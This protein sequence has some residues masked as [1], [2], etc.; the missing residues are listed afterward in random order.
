[1]EGD[2][3]TRFFHLRKSQRRRRNYISKLKNQDGQFTDNQVEMGVMATDFY[4]TLYM[5]E[6]T[7]N[8]NLVLDTVPA[9]V[10]MAM[11]ESLV[12]PFYKDEIKRVL[13]QMFPTKAPG[14]DG[15]PAHFFQRH[16]E[17]CGDEVT[18]VVLR[19]LRGE[20]DPSLINCTCIVLIP[21]VESPEELSQFRPISL[22]NVIYK[23][24]SKVMAN[25][26]KSVLPEIISEE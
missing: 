19:I 2:R 25:R 13:F 6:G 11:N 1:M 12:A 23:I 16:W 26:M 8:M 14:P 17:L 15:L 21:K 22:C 3:N 20:D 4:R 24:A 5:S 18:E 10:T 9:K 7:V